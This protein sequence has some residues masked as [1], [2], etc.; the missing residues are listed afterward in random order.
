MR[1]MLSKR[2]PR[3]LR[4]G[5]ITRFIENAIVHELDNT[6]RDGE[7]LLLQK[8]IDE[9]VAGNLRLNTKDDLTYQSMKK[10]IELLDGILHAKGR[11]LLSIPEGY[12]QEVYEHL[13]G[14]PFDDAVTQDS[15]PST[16]RHPAIE[17]MIKQL[18]DILGA[19]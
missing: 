8:K 11:L 12:A 17:A 3:G 13:C 6:P 19:Q 1:K 4:K 2:S 15:E 7:Y 14:I 5:D 16:E 9:L 18:S 10:E